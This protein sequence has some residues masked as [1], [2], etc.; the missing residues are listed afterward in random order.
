MTSK[1]T[2]L[3]GPSH[4]REHKYY[5]SHAPRPPKRQGI[6]YCADTL[7]LIAYFILFR[8]L[9][10]KDK[11]KLMIILKSVLSSLSVTQGSSAKIDLVPDLDN[12]R[13]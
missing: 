12:L 4:S 11:T 1:T 13:I 6:T 9:H 7:M 10:S 2:S 8:V 5:E 3:R